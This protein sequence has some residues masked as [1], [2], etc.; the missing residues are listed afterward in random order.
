MKTLR[1]K[2]LI[3]ILWWTIGVLWFDF[4]LGLGIF[5]ST[6]ASITVLRA[7]PASYPV[8]IPGVPF[9]GVKR[10]G[11]EAVHSPPSSA[12][13]KEWV[14]LYLRSPIRFLGVVLSEA[15][16]LHGIT[17]QKTSTWIFVTMNISNIVLGTLAPWFVCNRPI[18]LSCS[19]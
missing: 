15:T 19:K 12:E 13:I 14:E 16:T 4:R 3:C 5:L 18:F 10:S 1:Y 17:S 9:L 2:Q 6:T 7:H 8:G 11:R